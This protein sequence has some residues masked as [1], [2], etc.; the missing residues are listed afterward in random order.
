M[1][2]KI[3]HVIDAIIIDILS[4][5]LCPSEKFGN[6]FQLLPHLHLLEPSQSPSVVSSALVKSLS[7]SVFLKRISDCVTSCPCDVPKGRLF[8]R[9][10]STDVLLLISYSCPSLV[11]PVAQRKYPMFLE[12]G[13]SPLFY[14]CVNS[15]C[16]LC[17]HLLPYYQKA[18]SPQ[19]HRLWI[20]ILT[21]PYEICILGKVI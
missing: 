20:Q 12:H 19:G 9:G 17:G 8:L 16:Q 14:V 3:L 13:C 11:T 1:K 21:P 15:S 18:V 7:K 4:P 6:C 2:G 5:P 10:T